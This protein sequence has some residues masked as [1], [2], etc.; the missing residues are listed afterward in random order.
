[1]LLVDSPLRSPDHHQGEE[2]YENPEDRIPV[3]IY[4]L[5]RALRG[6]NTGGSIHF[7][8]VPMA[9]PVYHKVRS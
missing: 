6:K 1:M 9:T 3:L 7:D 4:R 5:D 8:A 2:D